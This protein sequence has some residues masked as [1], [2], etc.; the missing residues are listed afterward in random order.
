MLKEAFRSIAANKLRTALSMIGI[1]IG[2]AAVIAVVSVAEGTSRSI[3][4]NLS[5]IGSNLIM[6]SPGFTG[7]RGG[8]VSTSL[9]DLLTKD[10]AQKIQQFCTSVLYVTPVQQG[11]FIVQYERQNTFSTI[12]AVYP[13]IFNMMNLNLQEGEYFTQ[14]DENGRRRVAVIGKE[15]A[16]TLFPDGDAVG[17]TIK[18]SSQSIRQNYK[19]IGVLEKSGT[20]LFLNPDRSILVP[21]SSA[22]N[23]LFKRSYVSSIIAQAQSEEVAAEAVSQ[24]DSVLYSRFQ[25]SEKYR[26]ISQ[27]AMLQTINQTMA[28]L[29]FMLG[30]IAG[31][32]LLVGGIG[33]MNIMLVTVAERTREI[34]VRK[35]VGANRTHILTQFLLESIILTLVAGII[36]VGVGILLSRAIAL[37]GSIQ[38]AVTPVVILIAVSVSVAV[39][40]FFGVFPAMKASKLNPVEAL[41]YE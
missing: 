8:R 1:I 35:A 5:A 9:S 7:G 4:Q 19:I 3:K 13:Q 36:G 39:G 2:V 12:L 38:T 24:I 29:S 17:K 14:E 22:E 27:E 28:L 31:I 41:R 25:D 18:I 16:D 11:N 6:I 40:V 10:D 34:G 37:I 20:L 30:S 23:R 33:I 32:S 26:I 15:I 21:F